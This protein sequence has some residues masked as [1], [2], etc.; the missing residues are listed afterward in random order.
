M[1]GQSRVS[2]VGA[3]EV[4][5]GATLVFAIRGGSGQLRLAGDG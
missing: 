4:A 3:E 2:G 1:G 5:G